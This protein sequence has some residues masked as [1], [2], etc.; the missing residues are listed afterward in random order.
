M[1]T[2][3]SAGRRGL[4]LLVGLTALLS[5]HPVAAQVDVL[6]V[7]SI[8]APSSEGTVRVPVYLQDT[9]G[10]PIGIDRSFGKRIDDIAFAVLWSSPCI[11]PAAPFFDSSVGILRGHEPVFWDEVEGPRNLGWIIAFD[12]RDGFVPFTGSRDLLG[13]LVFYLQE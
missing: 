11:A 9:P 2:C 6:A 4:S 7:G 12:E 13:E 3:R 8:V 10:T 1:L 5:A